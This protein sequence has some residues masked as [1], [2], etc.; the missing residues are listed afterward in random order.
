MRV[1]AEIEVIAIA[2]VEVSAFAVAENAAWTRSD[3]VHNECLV[4]ELVDDSGARVRVEAGRYHPHSVF[5]QN[6]A[7]IRLTMTSR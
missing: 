4:E 1:L 6:M 3:V 5:L 7:I 2:A